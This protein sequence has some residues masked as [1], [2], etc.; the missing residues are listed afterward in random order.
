ME[1]ISNILRVSWS[2]TIEKELSFDD[3]PLINSYD[4]MDYK[5]NI[6]MDDMESNDDI[7]LLK[8]ENKLCN[9]IKELVL[10][11]K[12]KCIDKINDIL[13]ISEYLSY[14]LGLP[15][16]KNK[17]SDIHR[18]SYR[19]CSYNYKCEYNYNTGKYKGCYAQHYVHNSVYIDLLSLKNELLQLFQLKLDNIIYRYVM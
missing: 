12:D 18:S 6:N 19:F 16:N 2:G 14:K 4:N 10:S 8:Y 5:K 3:Q 11:N 9:E 15:I 1:Q 17:Y 13:K 7:S